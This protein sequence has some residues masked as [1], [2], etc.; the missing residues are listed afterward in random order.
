[1][2]K[3]NYSIST[4]LT[5]DSGQALLA[6]LTDTQKALITDIVDLQRAVSLLAEGGLP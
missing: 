4:S 3:A 5:A 6:D 2:G 1:M